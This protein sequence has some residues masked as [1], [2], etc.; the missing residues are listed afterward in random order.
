MNGAKP[1]T[2]QPLLF[3]SNILILYLRDALDSATIKL[4]Q[5][6]TANKLAAV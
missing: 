5:F 2:G 1:L 4:L 3:D 6:S